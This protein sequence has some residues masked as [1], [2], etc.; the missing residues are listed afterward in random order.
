MSL[1]SKLTEKSMIAKTLPQSTPLLITR[2]DDYTF[3]SAIIVVKY[4]DESVKSIN[5][6]INEYGVKVTVFSD[7]EEI[8]KSIKPLLQTNENV[9]EVGNVFLQEGENVE[10]KPVVEEVQQVNVGKKCDK[11]I[12]KLLKSF[13]IQGV[14]KQVINVEQL[15]NEEDDIERFVKCLIKRRP[16]E[17]TDSLLSDLYK[18]VEGQYGGDTLMDFKE[19][20]AEV[21]N[22]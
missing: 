21:F 4:D 15:E 20:I 18:I 12:K 10:T 5:D 14:E 6:I 3:D 13:T 16:V 1:K 9:L 22:L 17:L 19:V 2:R 8:L 7:S 11:L